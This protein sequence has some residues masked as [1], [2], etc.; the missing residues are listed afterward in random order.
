MVEVYMKLVQA[1]K[2]TLAEVPERYR[3]EVAALLKEGV[4]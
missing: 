2:R 3:N 4:E 1:G